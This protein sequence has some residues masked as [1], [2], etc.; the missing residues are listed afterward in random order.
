MKSDASARERQESPAF[1]PWMHRKGR[2]ELRAM[3]R[4]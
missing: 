1:I 4:Y 3:G 2:E